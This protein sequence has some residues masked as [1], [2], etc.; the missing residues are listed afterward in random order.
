MPKVRFQ[1]IR[2]AWDAIS[3][4]KETKINQRFQ[5]EMAAA[6]QALG[7]DPEASMTSTDK[8]GV[9]VKYAGKEK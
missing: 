3:L 7:D 1:K 6:G 9:T 4:A 2:L 5:G 8:V